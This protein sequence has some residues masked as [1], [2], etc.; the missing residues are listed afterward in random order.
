MDEAW[1]IAAYVVGGV[2]VVFG[3]TGVTLAGLYRLAPFRMLSRDAPNPAVLAAGLF[4]VALFVFTCAALVR[5]RMHGSAW[6]WWAFMALWLGT[7]LAEIPRTVRYLRSGELRRKRTT[8]LL[9]A[10][11]LILTTCAILGMG[12]AIVP[13]VIK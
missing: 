4:G 8:A 10:T 12:V 1:L 6:A 11:I 7:A 3:L 5:G 9:G 13:F 2:L